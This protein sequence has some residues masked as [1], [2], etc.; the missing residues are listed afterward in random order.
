M[1]VADVD[2]TLLGS[3]RDFV[4]LH[5]C[6]ARWQEV[7]LVPNSSRPIAS[8]RRSWRQMR[9]DSF[10][11]QVGALGTE[12]EVNGKRTGWS[13]RFATFDR[14][15]FDEVLTGMGFPTNGDEFQ[16]PLKASYSVTSGRWVEAIAAVREVAPVQVV[17]SGER[18]FDMIPVEAG[19]AA[20]LTF[21]AEELGVAPERIVAAGNSMNDLTMLMAASKRIVVGNADQALI[22]AIDGHAFCS[23]E[24]FAAGV[25]EGIRAL[26]VVR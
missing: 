3:D 8:L 15:P 25:K 19:K 20:P 22:D 12:V 6:L 5:R 7:A 14:R 17:T 4:D 13:K 16:T 2:G 26:G 11:T 23:R 10:T 18:D 24:H 1:V 21:L 9:I